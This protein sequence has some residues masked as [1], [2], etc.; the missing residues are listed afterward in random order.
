LFR[1]FLRLVLLVTA[2]VVYA[3]P[4]SAAGT[5]SIDLQ[6]NV[7]DYYGNRF[8]VTADGNVRVRLSD[9]TTVSGDTFS[10]DLKLNRFVVAGNVRVEGRTINEQAAAFASFP[11]VE[12]SYLLSESGTPDRYTYFGLDFTDQHKGREQPGDAFQLADTV[13]DRPFIIGHHAWIVPNT[14]ITMDSGV[15]VY[16]Y[17]AWLPLPSYVVNFSANPNYSQNAFSGATAD[18]GLPFTATKTSISAFH[19]RYDT[20]RGLYG[21]FDQHFVWGRD[22][23]VASVNPLTQMQRQWNLIAYKRNSIALETRLFYQ[24]ST[25]SEG[26]SQPTDVSSFTNAAV[27]TV[28]A[29]H[30]ISLSADQ[31]NNSLLTNNN[32]GITPFGLR[33]AAHP[34]DIQLAVQS[35]E[36][37][38]QLFR[39]VGVPVKFQYRFGLGYMHDTYG[40]PTLPGVNAD[41]TFT[42]PQNTATFTGGVQYPTIWQHFA[43]LSVYT[44]GIVIANGVSVA[45]KSDM[46]RQW[47]S[48]PHHIDTTQSSVTLARTPLTLKQP[49]FY[50]SYG[51]LTVGDNYGKDQLLA[52][53]PFG[54]LPPGVVPPPVVTPFGTYSGLDAFRGFAISHTW[55]GSVVYTPTPYFALNLQV[56]RA[57]DTPAPVPGLGGQPPWQF[58][59]DLRLRLAKNITID[60]TR[61]Y[62]FNFADNRWS[63]QFGIQFSP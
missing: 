55:T 22:Y 26:F 58:T 15:R 21:S 12:R 14:S 37:E 3:R 50:V 16:V 57:Y 27:N 40:I 41:G 10:M 6:A 11:D 39:H 63:P 9:G 18:V 56:R 35:F 1:L 44:P 53:P 29:K 54:G 59:G 23:V 2:V 33:V 5:S 34:F 17:G 31:W 61:S 20:F 8:V 25:L 36:N 24:L 60:L 45:L 52:Y 13:D 38:W 49:A 51:I 30:A 7:V 47:Y 32:T 43:G 48:L 19:A 46:Q 62:F 42:W 28:F 4:V